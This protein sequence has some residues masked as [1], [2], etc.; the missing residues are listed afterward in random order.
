MFILKYRSLYTF[1][2]IILLLFILSS[3]LFSDTKAETNNNAEMDKQVKISEVLLDMGMPL[4]QAENKK[5]SYD[6]NWAFISKMTS[7]RL[8]PEFIL[9]FQIPLLNN[10]KKIAI[11][12][13]IAKENQTKLQPKKEV[14]DGDKL[15]DNNNNVESNPVGNFDNS[16]P[17]VLIYHTHTHESF[18]ATSQYKYIPI[19]SDRSDDNNVNVVRLG[20]EL[21]KIL[22]ENGIGVL[23][24]TTVHDVPYE[25]AYERSIITFKNDLTKYPSI[26][27]AIDLHRDAYGEVMKKGITKIPD[28]NKLPNPDFRKKYLLERNGQRYAK[29]MFVIGTRRNPSDKEDWH[30]NYDFAEQVSNRVNELMPGLSLGID[31]KTYA[32]YNQQLLDHAVL[33]EVGSNYNTLEEALASIKYIGKAFSDV[34]NSINR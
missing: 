31:T 17:L 20:E 9:S 23:H 11:S 8:D 18:I 7:I 29:I 5:H 12:S 28:L 27:F 32:S 4:L 19:D 25:G 22:N 13:S 33:I 16:K 26:R 21:K 30:K 14:I 2:A 6:I 1:F 24:D 3:L 10:T 15:Q 34:I